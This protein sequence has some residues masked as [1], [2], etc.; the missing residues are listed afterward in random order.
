MA[1]RR[2]TIPRFVMPPRANIPRE[3]IRETTLTEMKIV[4][5][6]WSG[7]RESYEITMQLDTRQLRCDCEGFR[8]RH[9]CHHVAGLIWACYKKPKKRGGVAATSIMSYRAL[10]REDLGDRQRI[11]YET[12]DAHPDR[13]NR[14]LGEL[15]DWPINTVTPRV[16]ELREMGAVMQ[17]GTKHDI[18]TNRNVMTWETAVDITDRRPVSEFQLPANYLEEDPCH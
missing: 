17:C 5:P 18:A 11:V 2:V 16:K 3:W 14:E 13:C 4:F 15:L 6:S 1:E 9:K 8:Y 10:K 12:I 7:S